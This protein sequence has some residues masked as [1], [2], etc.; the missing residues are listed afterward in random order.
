M[1]SSGHRPLVRFV[2]ASLGL[3][4][5][6][7]LSAATLALPCHTASVSFVACSSQ[8]FP[9]SPRGTSSLDIILRAACQRTLPSILP[10][11]GRAVTIRARWRGE[12]QTNNATGPP[13][14]HRCPSKVACAQGG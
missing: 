10:C 13:P 3:A 2:Q 14:S 5:R 7:T 1:P 11:G 4:A 9:A 12:G 8:T 6:C